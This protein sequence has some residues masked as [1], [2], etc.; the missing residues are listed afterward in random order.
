ME[1]DQLN[2]R[3]TWN[4]FGLERA[5]FCCVVFFARLIHCFFT[6]SD[7]LDGK[8][9]SEHTVCGFS[10][11]WFENHWISHNAEKKSNICR[12][13]WKNAHWHLDIVIYPETDSTWYDHTGFSNLK[14]KVV[15]NFSMLWEPVLDG[16]RCFW[17]LSWNSIYSLIK[18]A[19]NMKIYIQSRKCSAQIR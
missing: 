15:R 17:P 13:A 10:A 5:Q 4:D 11:T 8:N 7:W 16:E 6:F 9:K 18:C 1:C 2:R 19:W 3:S 14:K 12:C